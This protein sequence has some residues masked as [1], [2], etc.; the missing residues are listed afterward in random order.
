MSPLAEMSMDFFGFGKKDF[1]FF[2]WE[3]LKGALISIGIGAAVYLVVRKWM[4]R[5]EKGESIYLNRWPEGLDLEER[6]YRPV[7]RILP[8]ALAAADRR[9]MEFPD[10]P[11][12]KETI[13][14]GIAGLTG[15]L[16]GLPES[17][18]CVRVIPAAVTALCRFLCELPERLTVVAHRI[19][20]RRDKTK[21]QVPVGNVFTYRLG[22]FLNRCAGLLNRTVMRSRPLRQDFEWVLAMQ[23]QEATEE[24]DRVVNSVSYGFLLMLA[25]IVIV[26]IVLLAHRGP[27]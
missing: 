24:Q 21:K 26:V 12:V 18:A 8:E 27:G 11:L 13:P 14:K 25:G 1:I 2:N 16:A 7:L 19:F 10:S 20:F 5:R 6:V 3:N 9:I 4:I 22:C 23:Q 17:F 15:F